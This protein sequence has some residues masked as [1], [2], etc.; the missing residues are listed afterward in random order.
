MERSS[1]F[2]QRNMAVAEALNEQGIATLLFDLLTSEEEVN[3]A[4]VFDIPLLAERVV[5]ASNGPVAS[6]S[7]SIFDRLFAPHGGGGTRGCGTASECI[8]AIV[9][10]VD[11]PTCRRRA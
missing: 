1:R 6:H 2:S 9:S 7:L 4:N 8:G 5:D 11:V 3:R 10:R